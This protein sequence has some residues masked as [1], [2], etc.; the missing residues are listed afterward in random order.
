MVN[1]Q[2]ADWRRREAA[3][4]A[5]GSILEGPAEQ[6]LQPLVA[7]AKEA[8]KRKAAGSACALFEEAFWGSAQYA[9]LITAANFR[10]KLGEEQ[11]AVAVYEHVLA[12][13]GVPARLLAIANKKLMEA[14]D[15][16]TQTSRQQW[17]METAAD[18]A[19]AREELE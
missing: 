4:L 16:E 13:P 15:E 2:S 14:T 6:V 17:L 7:Q 12:R 8:A 11:T 5:F 9:H 10:L 19:K 18:P 3:T 1:A